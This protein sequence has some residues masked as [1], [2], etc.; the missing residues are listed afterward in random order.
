MIEF[1]FTDLGIRFINWELLLR[2]IE[3]REIL[4]EVDLADA[5]YT[6]DV[7]LSPDQLTPF[8]L[9][10]QKNP[11][12]QTVSFHSLQLSSDFMVPFLDN[13]T[14]V[15]ELKLS[16]CDMETP[17]DAL[18]IAAVFQRNTTVQRLKLEWINEV[19]MIPLLNSLASEQSKSKLRS[20][21]LLFCAVLQPR[22][23]SFRVAMLGILQPDSLL[24]CLDLSYS[25]GFETAEDFARLFTAVEL[26]PLE[27]FNIRKLPDSEDSCIE[28][29]ASIPKMQL[30]T[31]EVDLDRDLPY[32]KRDFIRAVKRNASLRTVVA[33]VGGRDDWLNC[34]DRQKLVSYSRRNEFLARWSAKPTVV[35]KAAWPEALDVARTT[36]PGTVFHILRALASALWTSE[37]EPCRKRRRSDSLS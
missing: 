13:A 33:R 18:V 25:G 9:A 4:V 36:G 28:L 10:I 8:L 20:L 2:L 22:L 5:C 1:D 29:I 34:D 7:R 32:L 3:A 11:R 26:S 21:R 12:V 24:R 31:L 23:E 27:S 14:S 19:L 15:R 6:T 16:G 17:A 35:P 37:G 30:T